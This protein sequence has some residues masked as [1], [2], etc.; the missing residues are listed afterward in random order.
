MNHIKRLYSQGSSSNIYCTCCFIEV[1]YLLF[2]HSEESASIYD[3]CDM[4][5]VWYQ[6]LG[7][8]WTQEVILYQF[9]WHKEHGRP[10]DGAFAAIVFKTTLALHSPRSAWGD[11]FLSVQ[12]ELWVKVRHC[13][14]GLL[15]CCNCAVCTIRIPGSCSLD[16]FA[17]WLRQYSLCFNLFL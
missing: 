4:H 16:Y 12:T 17:M 15:S 6:R 2:F 11:V 14:M 13:D 1:L 7:W 9:S 5:C 10:E 8:F 3:I